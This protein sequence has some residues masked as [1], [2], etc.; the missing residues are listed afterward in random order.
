MAGLVEADAPPTGEPD[1]GRSTPSRVVDAALDDDAPR[2][3]VRSR[4]LDVVAY[5][6]QLG[7]AGGVGRM[8]RHL[9]RWQLLDQP[10][11]TRVDVRQPEQALEQGPVRIG[12]G[13][14]E[15]HVRAQDHV[16][17]RRTWWIPIAARSP[18]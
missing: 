4:R 9:P 8:H 13:A 5:E 1:G 2:R 7:R 3:Q 16:P 6:V 12:V 18:G 17:D 15:D 14:V 11:A 10:A